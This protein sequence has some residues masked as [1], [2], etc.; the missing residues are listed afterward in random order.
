MLTR[1]T[2]TPSRLVARLATVAL[3]TAG[4]QAC[5]GGGGGADAAPAALTFA[6]CFGLQARVT[7]GVTMAYDYRSSVFDA[8]GNASQSF[9]SSWTQFAN[10]DVV[11]EGAPRSEFV[12]RI[13]STLSDGAVGES[14]LR[15]YLTST[16]ATTMTTYGGIDRSTSSGGTGPTIVEV[17][18]SVQT[19][20][21]TVDLGGGVGSSVSLASTSATTTTITT[22]GV[23]RP[24]TTGTDTSTGTLTFAAVET[25]TVP[26]G[27][28]ST[29]RLQG[30]GVSASD[31]SAASWY[32]PGTG[33]AARSE[34]YGADGKVTFRSEL[35]R[36]TRNGNPL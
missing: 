7:P 24:A 6:E 5:G 12:L 26:A 31:G 21:N 14:E 4:L 34:G 17:V 36:L 3:A 32:I 19:P 16:A 18:K 25:I 35:M 13:T 8:Q 27:T 1:R 10:A 28:Y 11:F 29:C 2:P 15:S 22:D 20:P 9:D 33:V 30:V 23:A